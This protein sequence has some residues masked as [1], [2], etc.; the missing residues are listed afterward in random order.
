MIN[1]DHSELCYLDESTS[2]L[3]LIRVNILIALI[4]K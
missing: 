1:E 2:T 4:K 3:W